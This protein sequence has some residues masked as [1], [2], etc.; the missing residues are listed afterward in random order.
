MKFITLFLLVQLQFYNVMTLFGQDPDAIYQVIELDSLTIQ[1]SR[2]DLDVKSY[3]D[4]MIQDESFYTAFKNLR[5]RSYSFQNNI[6][7]LDKN[8]RTIARYASTAYQK[9]DQSCR[10]MTE[11]NKVI[12]GDFMDRKGEYEYYTAKLFDRL[13]FTHGHVCSDT[14]PS[15]AAVPSRMEKQVSELKKLMFAPGTDARVPLLGDKTAIFSEDMRPYYDYRIKADLLNGQSCYLFEVEV[16]PNFQDEKTHKTVIKKL[17]TWF[18]EDNRQILQRTYHLTG[19]TIAYSFDVTMHVQVTLVKDQ[20]VPTFIEYNGAWKVIG[21][22]REI[23]KFTV[24]FS[25]FK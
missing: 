11:M 8:Q 24:T 20:Y 18:D 22:K 10:T 5:Y 3:I 6:H 25:D 1:A 4:W 7:I 19:K 12:T 14:M 16:K 13:F 9:Y 23:A 15:T 2:E 21:K 17:Q